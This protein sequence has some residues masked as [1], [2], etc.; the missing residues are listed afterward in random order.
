MWTITSH[1]KRSCGLLYVPHT[2]GV[3]TT[4]REELVAVESETSHTTSMPFQGSQVL[5]RIGI[6]H[7][8]GPILTTREELVAVDG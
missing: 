1:Q 7:T 5:V 8:N 6:P 2:N 4:T 3:I